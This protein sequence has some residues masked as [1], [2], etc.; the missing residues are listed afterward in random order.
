MSYRVYSWVDFACVAEVISCVW[1][2]CFWVYSRVKFRVYG[3]V[4]HRVYS[5][6]TNPTRKKIEVKLPT[7]LTDGEAEVGRVNEEKSRSEKIREE[8]EWEARDAGARKGKKVATHYLFP[9]IWRPGRSVKRPGGEMRDEKSHA[10]VARSTFPS[11]KIG[12]TSTP[13]HFWKFRCRKRRCGWK[14]IFNSNM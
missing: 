1:L 7:I 3:W 10:F 14:Q 5:W 2:S 13:D 12:E 11:Q 9:M 8:K 6:V 4:K